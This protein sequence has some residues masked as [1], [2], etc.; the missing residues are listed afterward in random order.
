MVPVVYNGDFT[1][2]AV[3]DAIADLV[4]NGSRAAP[5]FMDPEGVIVF[6]P[7]ANMMFKRTIKADESPKSLAA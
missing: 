2:T 4:A 3:D 5:G 1:T 7:A 6:H